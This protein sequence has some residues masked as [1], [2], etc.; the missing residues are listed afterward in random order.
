MSASA[1]YAQSTLSTSTSTS[2]EVLARHDSQSLSLPA[3][4]AQLVEMMSKEAKELAKKDPAAF[5]DKYGTH[6]ISLQ[7]YGCK[8][9][10]QGSYTF[11]SLKNSQEFKASLETKFKAGAFSFAASAEVEKLAKNAHENSTFFAQLKGDIFDIHPDEPSRLDSWAKA[12]FE[13]FNKECEANKERHEVKSVYVRSWSSLLTTIPA[14]YDLDEQ[15]IQTLMKAKL[16]QQHTHQG[17]TAMA[18]YFSKLGVAQPGQKQWIE[19][20]GQT[21]R[22]SPSGP[23]DITGPRGVTSAQLLKAAAEVNKLGW[24][25]NSKSLSPSERIAAFLK[26]A[27]A[28]Y[29][30]YVIYANQLIPQVTIKMRRDNS[31][32]PTTYTINAF[33]QPKMNNGVV[34]VCFQYSSP[35][36]GRLDSGCKANVTAGDKMPVN[37][38]IEFVPM[39]VIDPK[40]THIQD[41]LKVVNPPQVREY[42]YTY[43]E[44]A[45]T[46]SQC[47]MSVDIDNPKTSSCKGYNWLCTPWKKDKYAWC[48]P[49]TSNFE[50]DYSI[51]EGTSDSLVDY[52]YPGCSQSLL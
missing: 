32:T 36:V 45:P 25:N 33:D 28:Q 10:M 4:N 14:E 22:D 16:T 9:E 51:L 27:S 40:A 42:V 26:E 35:F 21:C 1:S 15:N 47:Q 6:F 11:D 13:N 39:M 34:Q 23:Y 19:K 44:Y 20:L 17:L 49:D 24:T 3:E 12:L 52:K 38:K 48:V 31:L 30:Q 37:D 2:V 5:V 50:I 7:Q 29:K 8:A 43:T 46:T 18:N 41:V